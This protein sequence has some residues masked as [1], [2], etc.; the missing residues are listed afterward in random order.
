[1][2]KTETRAGGEPGVER[3]IDRY[4]GN[5]I[6]LFLSALALLIFVAAV[7]AA[8]ETVAHDFPKLWRQSDEYEVLH[9][10]IQSIL[11]VAIAAELG[12]LLLFH[13]TSAAIEVVIF[14]IARKMVTP[15]IPALELLLGAAALAGLIVVRFYYLPDKKLDVD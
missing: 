6:H 1:V 15:G 4:L 11:L 12:L 7:I 14:V 9:Q 10:I 13:R 2:D 5:A 8:Y 3:V